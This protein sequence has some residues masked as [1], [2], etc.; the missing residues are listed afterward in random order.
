MLHNEYVGLHL[1]SVLGLSSNE[2]EEEEG[3]QHLFWLSFCRLIESVVHAAE[4]Q[5]RIV[6]HRKFYFLFSDINSS[7]FFRILLTSILKYL[8]V[9]I[10]KKLDSF[11]C[12]DFPS[13]PV[14]SIL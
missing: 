2:E 6:V 7:V 3:F 11:Q 12:T 5:M 4:N 8:G 13:R 9:D 14:W 10:K 1:I